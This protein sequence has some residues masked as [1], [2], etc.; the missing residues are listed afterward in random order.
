MK[1]RVLMEDSVN[2]EKF[3]FAMFYEAEGIIAATND[4][5]FEFPEATVV[6]V[7]IVHPSLGELLKSAIN[8][9]YTERGVAV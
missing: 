4:A 5:A 6:N 1:Y 9:L 8:K 7:D 2:G 3:N